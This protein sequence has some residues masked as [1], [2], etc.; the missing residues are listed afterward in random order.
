MN[1]F[2]PELIARGQVEDDELLNRHEEEWD[3]VCERYRAYLDTIRP[4]MPPGLRHI[5]QSY[6]LHDALIRGMARRPGLFTIV[7]RLDTPPGSLL[8]FTYDLVNEPIILPDALPAEARSTGDIVDWQYD[9]IEMVPGHP[10]TWAQSILFSNGWEVRL[11][12]RDVQVQ[13]F[14]SLIPAPRPG[15]RLAPVLAP[16]D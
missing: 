15:T 8:T 4:H 14:E 16:T 9:E 6:Y 3:L 11:H 13:E 5:D 12:F 7:L 10:P 1:Y 2:T